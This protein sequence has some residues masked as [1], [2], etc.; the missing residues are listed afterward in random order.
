M[1]TPT[2][3]PKFTPDELTHFNNLETL[4]DSLNTA[5]RDPETPDA[6]LPKLLPRIATVQG[7]IQEMNAIAFGRDTVDLK[8]EAEDL[9]PANTD[10]KQ[11]K[12]DL[13]GYAKQTA[14]LQKVA[15]ALDQALASAQALGI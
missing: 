12:I 2:P 14:T 8:A 13:A 15:G 10:L 6:V 3:S 11:L 4:F 5:A 1:S 7:E 9:R